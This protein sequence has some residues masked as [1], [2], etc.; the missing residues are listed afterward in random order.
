MKIRKND[1]EATATVCS[2]LDSSSPACCTK[3]FVY[4]KNIQIHSITYIMHKM[5]PKLKPP[6]PPPPPPPLQPLGQAHL[7]VSS[8]FCMCVKLLKD[9]R[10]CISLY[11][12]FEVKHVFVFIQ[13]YQ[14]ITTPSDNAKYTVLYGSK[15]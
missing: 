1:Q 14:N 12:V 9:F 3:V 7:L 2:I 10:S 13:W 8:Y 4:Y 11:Y 15:Q 5:E 6:P